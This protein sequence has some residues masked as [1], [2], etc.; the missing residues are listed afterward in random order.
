MRSSADFSG[1]KS[2][3]DARDT[4]TVYPPYCQTPEP[5]QALSPPTYQRSDQINEPLEDERANQLAQALGI[6][7]DMI[8]TD[9][10]Y[11]RKRPPSRWVPIERVVRAR[12]FELSIF[13]LCRF[14]GLRFEFLSVSI[15]PDEQ[16]PPREK[17]ADRG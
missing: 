4:N 15:E 16:A 10:E 11:Q 6:E 1:S 7:Q 8:L 17:Q 5:W 9:S 2:R 3:I 14:H 13:A 12:L